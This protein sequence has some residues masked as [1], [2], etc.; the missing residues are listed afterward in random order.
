MSFDLA[1]FSGVRPLEPDAAAEAYDV[2]CEGELWSNVLEPDE[3]VADFVRAITARWP[4]FTDVPNDELHLCPWSL[5]LDPSPA[6]VIIHMVHSM[7]AE[8][9]PFC[10]DT[11]LAHG[12]NVF[13]PQT[14]VLHSPGHEPRAATFF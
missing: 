14:A 11:A 10:V 6:H 4:Q 3:R 7:A 2:L 12:L 9:A 5:V 1:V 13:D 8:V